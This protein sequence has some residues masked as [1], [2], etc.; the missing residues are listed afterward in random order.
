MS[1]LLRTRV[2]LLEGITTGFASVSEITGTDL[3]Y[4]DGAAQGAEYKVYL[5]KTGYY[6]YN[7]YVR[8]DGT[9]FCLNETDMLK[10]WMT[11]WLESI[12]TPSQPASVQTQGSAAPSESAHT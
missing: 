5:Y 2:H 8:K 10:K 7:I 6:N 3:F 1:A 9:W 12:I 4:T 11:L